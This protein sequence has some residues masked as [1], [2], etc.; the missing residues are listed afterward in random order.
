ML[1]DG[2]GHHA[3]TFSKVLWISDMALKLTFHILSVVH[4]YCNYLR[5]RVWQT[6][7]YCPRVYFRGKTFRT[8]LGQLK[9]LPAFFDGAP[10]I[11]MSGTLITENIAGCSGLVSCSTGDP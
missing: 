3:L 1:N 6:G 11:A 7:P 8:A 5:T 9:S 4:E 2:I 10:V